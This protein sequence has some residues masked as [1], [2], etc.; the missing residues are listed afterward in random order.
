MCASYTNQGSLVPFELM[1]SLLVKS[2]ASS[3]GNKFL[4]DGFPRSMEQA[5]YL[6][7][8]IKEIK[9]ILNIHASDEI[10]LSRIL[11]RGA[12]SGRADDKQE[13]TIRNRLR[14]F[15]DQSLPV[16]EFYRKYGIVRDVNSE[17]EVNQVYEIVKKQL[18]P[19]VYCII[20]K[21]YSGKTTLANVLNQRMGMKVI[22]FK[23]FI[24]EPSIAKRKN[25]DLF[26]ISS[27][28]ARLREEDSPRVILEDFPMKKEYF[29][30]FVKNCKPFEKIFYLN[31][32]DNE[33]FE[34]MNKIGYNHPNYIGCA[35]LNKRLFEFSK[36]KD[37][38]EYLR[39]Q[40]NLS[41]INVNN[42]LKSVID[43]FVKNIQPTILL[44][45][46][47]TTEES[48]RKIKKELT[49]NLTHKFGFEII[50][51]RELINESVSRFNLTGRKIHNN[52]KDQLEIPFE[53]ILESI[54]PVL[55]KES[56]N[57]CILEDYP[58]DP[59]FI[60]Q[61]E[62]T[63][64]KIHKLIY[65]SGSHIL[66]IEDK[67]IELY[68][69]RLNKLFVYNK[70]EIDEYII[71]DILGKNRNLHVVYGMPQSGK[72]SII[73]H[74]KEKYNFTIIDFVHLINELKTEKG[75]LEDPPAEPENVEFTFAELL[76]GFT[77]KLNYIPLNQKISFEN[78]FN[79][80]VVEV[81]QVKKILDIAGRI[82]T[83]YEI[84]Y[85]EE[86][87]IDRYKHEQNIEEDLTEDQRAA[88]EETLSKPKLIIE[89][90]RAISYKTK[91]IYT[92]L[93]VPKSLQ[94]FD[95]ESG[96]NIISIKHDYEYDIDN[97]LLLFA[98]RQQ[99]LFVN[100]PNLIYQEF[101]NNTEI[102][103]QLENYYHKKTLTNLNI[104][105]QSI[106]Y[107]YSPIHFDGSIVD[108][109]ITRYINENSAEMEEHGNYV[110]ITG[111]LNNDLLDKQ[112]IALNLPLLEV[113]KLM[114]LGKN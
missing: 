4:I 87:L 49:Y 26:V 114:D 16:I 108:K 37:Y 36:H 41:E 69:K 48:S 15:K 83:F 103:H 101:Y 72:T 46:N 105:R 27:L 1:I 5:L 80:L 32:N 14:E 31:V 111:Y 92:H 21:K 79:E 81:D 82:K 39:K 99:A 63:I 17:F 30:L 95:E 66:P 33:S 34:R 85:Q 67:S 88:F 64:C 23:D 3:S 62:S 89:H 28:A 10:S 38:L 12:I 58:N 2:I 104:D 57:K 8:N 74:L 76:E 78:I 84:N 55:F 112:E 43:E 109:L 35:E 61:F 53:L 96:K 22:D 110:I 11:K 52:L 7:K 25:D 60:H 73:N 29:S 102:A 97:S 75:K 19:A 18:Y 98:A 9:A 24:N 40:A 91:T 45:N 59:E 90:L 94:L 71:D 44:I 86:V 13:V 65:V 68:F 77:K 6:E 106:Y 93:S 54:K 47:D 56:N 113:M 100:V 51:V 70:S 42:H 20:G 50:N 107:K